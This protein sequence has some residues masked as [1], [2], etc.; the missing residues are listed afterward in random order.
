MFKLL[1]LCFLS[2]AIPALAINEPPLPDLPESF[3]VTVEAVIV[4]KNYSMTM[5]EHYDYDNNV[6]SFFRNTPEK[7]V[8]TVD[9]IDHD[10]SITI[11]YDPTAPGVS[12]FHGNSS[13]PLARNCT[14]HAASEFVVD[15]KS[16]HL[17]TTEEMFRFG[18]QFDEMYLGQESVRGI[19]C[20]HWV[21]N[22]TH[23]TFNNGTSEYALHWY[24][25]V[26]DWIA[27]GLHRVPVRARIIGTS[28]QQ[29]GRSTDFDHYYEYMNFHTGRSM[30]LHSSVK[31]GRYKSWLKGCDVTEYCSTHP[32]NLDACPIAADL[33]VN[34]EEQGDNEDGDINPGNDDKG[35]NFDVTML[36]LILGAGVGVLLTSII[37]LFFLNPLMKS[38][39]SSVMRSN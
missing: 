39:N 3:E 30:W 29:D 20:D 37:F 11:S 17:K 33:E 4:N 26:E 18:K 21:H 38:G 8:W 9:Y 15:Q 23:P 36:G 5:V 14:L 25:A 6:I 22:I 35:A 27:D 24:F 13:N 32:D 34:D 28:T 2:L 7:H 10:E 12:A 31:E 1:E 19:P 16:H